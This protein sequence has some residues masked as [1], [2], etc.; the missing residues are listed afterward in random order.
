MSFLKPASTRDEQ[1]DVWIGVGLRYPHYREA[2]EGTSAIDF[3]ELHAE[4]FFASGGLT[5]SLLQEVSKVYEISLHSTSLGLGSA[6]GINGV[7]LEKLKALVS[8]VEPVLV[9]DH[10]SF[11]WSTYAGKPVHAGDLLP[12]EFTEQSLEVMA[13][14]VD[15]VQQRLG[16]RLLVENLSAYIDL[17]QPQMSETEFL[18][19]LVDRSQCGLLIDLNNI[20]V[21]THNFGN[22]D[23]LSLAKKWL[24]EVPVTAVGE[25]HLAG[26]TKVPPGE[27]IIDDHSRA[28]S[29]ECWE[30]YRF[31]MGHFG[32]VT[33]LIEWDNELPD[34]QVLLDQ[35]EKART[36]ACAVPQLDQAG[37]L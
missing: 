32:P 35:A 17:G 4:N 18:S 29:E 21:N 26:Y 6:L 14:N 8:E 13:A 15:R 36:I 19:R 22:A 25:L 30:L 23:S 12:L 16:R 33:S 5:R 2:L 31:A 24:R 27:L 1:G 34:W 7:Y 10:A 20:L 3:V 37:C 11:A 9:S 28:V